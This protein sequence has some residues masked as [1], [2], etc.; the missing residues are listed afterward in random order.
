M[1]IEQFIASFPKQHAAGVFGSEVVSAHVISVE[2]DS[3]LI[4][5][6][7]NNKVR[8]WKMIHRAGVLWTTFYMTDTVIQIKMANMAVDTAPDFVAQTNLGAGKGRMVP[9]WPSASMGS[10]PKGCDRTIWLVLTKDGKSHLCIPYAYNHGGMVSV[11]EVPATFASLDK[12]LDPVNSLAHL[13]IGALCH[14]WAVSGEYAE[15]LHKDITGEGARHGEYFGV[16]H[17]RP[18][19][20]GISL[21]DVNGNTH[22]QTNPFASRYSDKYV[23]RSASWN[24]VSGGT[25]MTIEKQHITTP[26]SMRGVNVVEF[27]FPRNRV[28]TSSVQSEDIFGRKNT[29]LCGFT[30]VKGDNLCRYLWR[31]DYAKGHPLHRDIKRTKFKEEYTPTQEPNLDWTWVTETPIEDDDM[32]DDEKKMVGKWFSGYLQNKI[33]R[34]EGPS[35]EEVEFAKRLGIYKGN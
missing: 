33:R 5:P 27:H 10:A 23:G 20:I 28:Q 13:D 19:N 9:N 22:V 1:D 35:D 11:V 25:S 24:E 15:Q 14:T 32:T 17:A 29:R 21:Y 8:G 34:G 12:D 7:T 3:G 31:A 18:S 26:Y 30:L 4:E 16:I 2:R 6:F